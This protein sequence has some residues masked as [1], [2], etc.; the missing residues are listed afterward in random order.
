L[1]GNFSPAVQA[2][3]ADNGQ[4]QPNLQSLLKQ[5]GFGKELIGKGFEADVELAAK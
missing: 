2:A 5:C 4:S 1:P 3:T